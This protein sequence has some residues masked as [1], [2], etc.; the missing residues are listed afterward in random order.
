MK[1]MPEARQS[2]STDSSLSEIVSRLS[3]HPAVDAL[4]LAGS[5]SRNELNPAS[6][7]DLVVVLSTMPIPLH[8]G[9]TMIDHRFAD[10]IFHTTQQTEAFLA[11][12]EPLDFW[13]WTG[14]L[15]GWLE[16]GQIVFDRKGYVEKAQQKAQ[17]GK[18]VK[19]SGTETGV[20]AWNG[21]NYNL[22]VVRRYLSSDDPLYWETADLKMMIYGP[23]DLFFNYFEVRRLQWQG[24][25][26]AINY[27]HRHDPGYLTLFHQFLREHDRRAK[28]ALY[29]ELAK[30]TVAPVGQLWQAAE[31]IIMV[32]AEEVTPEME[33]EALDFWAELIGG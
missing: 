28:F 13:S 14:R 16:Q 22:Q 10:V 25:K 21:V 1:P 30:Q 23:A 31:T 11:A 17:G 33:G 4:L 29:E 15:V 19:P 18:W 24:E 27:L 8:V 20:K 2:T 6:D 5:A 26:A 3:R 32:D 9:V 12:S 7:Y